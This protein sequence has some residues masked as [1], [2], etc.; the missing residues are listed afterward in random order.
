[1]AWLT[2]SSSKINWTVDIHASRPPMRFSMNCCLV[3]NFHLTFFHSSFNLNM[4]PLINLKFVLALYCH[5]SWKKIVIFTI[6]LKSSVSSCYLIMLHTRS[7][8]KSK[9]QMTISKCNRSKILWTIGLF[10]TIHDNAVLSALRL[11]S[12]FQ[13]QSINQ[14]D[15][16]LET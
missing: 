8:I 10:S 11:Y 6:G 13:F 9:F 2:I 15:F 4:V 12:E 7:C 1:M 3:I 16:S 14:A 5:R